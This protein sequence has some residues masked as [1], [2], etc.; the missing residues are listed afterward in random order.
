MSNVRVDFDFRRGFLDVD[1][2]DADN[3]F[4]FAVGRVGDSL[5]NSD[6]RM[7]EI[8]IV[9]NWGGKLNIKIFNCYVDRHH[10]VVGTV[11]VRR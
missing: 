5:N 2:S 7:F 1:A 8:R 11:L 4:H 10:D 3:R 9:N 6:F